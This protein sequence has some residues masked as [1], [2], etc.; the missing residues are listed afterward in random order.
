[1]TTKKTSTRILLVRHGVT[2][3][4]EEGRIHGI[5]DRPLSPYGL[6]QAELTGKALKN[7]KAT[8]MFVSPL[9]R[10]KQT[11][12]PIERTTGLK[13]EYLDGL[14]EKDLGRK[15]GKRRLL[16][17]DRHKLLLK[18]IP[19]L[20]K[21]EHLFSKGKDTEFNQR[22]LHTW[23]QICSQAKG[24]DV[25]II[26]SH[27][28]VL[29]SILSQVLGEKKA[30]STNLFLATCSI[31]E[32]EISPDQPAKVIKINAVEHLDNKIHP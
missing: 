8:R 19:T 13:A 16:R 4:L 3:W 26:V 6:E 17:L 32:I 25:F 18:L 5:S 23:E 31:C 28:G 11:A 21:I 29:R 14:I 20:V 27:S 22:V 1:M 12:A 10:A 24:N 15:E 7:S 2:D 9:L 30:L